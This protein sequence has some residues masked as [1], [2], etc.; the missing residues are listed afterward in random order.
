LTGLNIVGIVT[1]YKDIYIPSILRGT[2][3]PEEAD[4]I[5]GQE[6]T[7]PKSIPSGL[8]TEPLFWWRQNYMHQERSQQKVWKK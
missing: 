6:E 3:K 8:L 5:L 4:R 1:K 2:G 7:A